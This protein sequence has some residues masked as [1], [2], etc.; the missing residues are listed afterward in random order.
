CEPRISESS[1]V[2]SKTFAA[3]AA[4][5]T[6][7]TRCCGQTRPSTSPCARSSRDGPRTCTG[8]DTNCEIGI[9]D[10][11]FAASGRRKPDGGGRQASAMHTLCVQRLIKL[12]DGVPRHLEMSHEAE[13]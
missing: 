5:C 12:H 4:T 1:K 8:R 10:F 3:A 6:W 11:G 13:T 7:I 9:S 2:F